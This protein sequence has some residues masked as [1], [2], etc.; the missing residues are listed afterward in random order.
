MRF[1][2][3]YGFGCD[4]LRWNLPN[5]LEYINPGG[6]QILNTKKVG[7]VTESSFNMTSGGGGGGD[8]DIETR[9]LKF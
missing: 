2:P 8:E 3:F 1:L 4:I 5:L 9:T 7:F 6:M